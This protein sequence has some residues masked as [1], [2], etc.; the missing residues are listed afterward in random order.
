MTPE[1]IEDYLEN[2]FKKESFF[3]DLK[4]INIENTFNN[5]YNS[6]LRQL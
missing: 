2:D 1:S 6:L 5:K 4:N 3:L